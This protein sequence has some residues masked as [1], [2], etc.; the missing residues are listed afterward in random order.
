MH[1]FSLVEDEVGGEEHEQAELVALARESESRQLP[2]QSA[3]ARPRNENLHL[4]R[5]APETR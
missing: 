5:A 2:S 1:E 3:Q 4:T